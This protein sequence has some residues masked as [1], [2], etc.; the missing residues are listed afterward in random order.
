MLKKHSWG[1]KAC[2]GVKLGIKKVSS[3]LVS[4]EVFVPQRVVSRLEKYAVKLYKTH[5][6]AKGF[7]KGK[8]P[9]E[10]VKEYFKKQLGQDV[11]KFILKFVV[12]DFLQQA[13]NEKDGPSFQFP[14]LKGVRTETSGGLTYV[15]S[16][17]Q[18]NNV[19][20]SDWKKLS[21]LPPR[22]K[23]YKDLDRQAKMFIE[24]EV[25]AKPRSDKN[26]KIQDGDWVCF[27]SKVLTDDSQSP[28]KEH[29]N[30]FWMK[31]STKYLVDPFQELFFD[32]QSGEV[33]SVNSLPIQGMPGD[34][35]SRKGKFDIK[36]NSVWRG[37]YFCLDLFKSAFGLASPKD[38]HDKLIEV[39]SFRN[40]ISQR[41]SIVEE[42]FR[43][44]LSRFRLE[45]PRHLVLRR[46]EH[47]LSSVKNL[48]DYHVYKSNSTF[49]D[50]IEE[51]SERQL[52][53]ETIIDFIARDEAIDL[54]EQDIH[55]YLNLLSNSRLSEFI[56]FKP[57]AEGFGQTVL[58]IREKAFSAEVLRE[59]ALNHVINT[60]GRK[61]AKTL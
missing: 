1:C 40:D 16:A 24:N 59:K 55:K 27:T 13:N 6:A 32:R 51:L 38:V 10:Y 3:S 57:Q 48:P 61:E 36:I 58:P 21:F 39:F 47:I 53:E 8:I 14:R 37:G 49:F 9:E 50:Q 22:R 25:D 30:R 34:T 46:Q 35:L 15:F 17:S 29:T 5:G 2:Q 41:R 23:L 19:N 56:Y 28:L 33:L 60:I 18:V 43:A 11:K 12:L 44:L 54:E 4:I 7:D 31:I 45:V 26:W 52:R 42:A 20:L